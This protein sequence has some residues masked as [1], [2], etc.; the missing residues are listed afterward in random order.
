MKNS[1]DTLPYYN[2]YEDSSKML[3]ELAI[4]YPELNWLWV[5]VDGVIIENNK[6]DNVGDLEDQVEDL[7][8][9]LEA[10][11]ADAKLVASRIEQYHADHDESLDELHEYVLDMLNEM[12]R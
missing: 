1:I 5:Q 4:R 12:S 2:L 8:C 3:D 10:V 6:L 11:R 7:K 9:D